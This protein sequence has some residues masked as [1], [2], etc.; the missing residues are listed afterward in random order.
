[1]PE[2]TG[3]APPSQVLIT[4]PIPTSISRKNVTFAH[5]NYEDEDIIPG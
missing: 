3:M 4:G 2:T 5:L 1:M